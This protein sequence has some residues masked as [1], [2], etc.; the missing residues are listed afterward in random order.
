MKR[1]P[2]ADRPLINYD[3]A[4]LFQP[5]SLLGVLIGVFVNIMTP[6]WLMVALSAIVLTIIT[7]TTLVKAVKM[8]KSEYLAKQQL[9]H[10]NDVAYSQINDEGEIQ[11]SDSESE[12][13][14]RPSSRSNQNNQLEASLLDEDQLV[15]I[16]QENIDKEERQTYA[17]KLIN[18]ERSTPFMKLFI[19]VMCWIIVFAITIMR[20]G[21]GAPSVLMIKHCSPW[22][23]VLFAIMF[24]IMIV[25]T[26]MVGIYLV[27][28]HEE[29]QALVDSGYRFVTGDINFTPWNVTLYPIIAGISG[30]FAGLLG[31]GGGM[32]KVSNHYS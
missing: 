4:L 18:A 22:Y 23:W 6:A 24:P 14:D 28:K 27:K 9:L 7:F 16:E 20:G 10:P 26:V 29:R 8:W 1:H 5:F 3:V 19:L 11:Q 12:T 30:F 31:V 21:H 32:I 13:F 17:K 25:I 15:R 2:N